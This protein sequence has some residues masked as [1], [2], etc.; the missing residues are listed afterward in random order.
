MKLSELTIDLLFDKYGK[1]AA[2]IIIPILD[3]NRGY[4]YNFVVN[5]CKFTNLFIDKTVNIATADGLLIGIVDNK[6]CFTDF[7]I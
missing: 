3:Y 2:S 4:I 5:H 7:K 6:V 1:N